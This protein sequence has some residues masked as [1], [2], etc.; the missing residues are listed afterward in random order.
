MAL[1]KLPYRTLV[2]LVRH[3]LSTDDDDTVDLI[4]GLRPARARGYLSPSDLEKV[5]CWKSP[6]AL[7]YIRSNS[8]AHVR[9]AT[10]RAL[11]TRSERR[12]LDAL[13]ELRGVSVPMASAILMLVDPKRYGVIDIRVWQVLHAVG[14]VTKKPSGIG[15][16]FANWYQFLMI[17]RYF[18]KILGVSARDVE[19]ALFVA[20]KDHQKGRL[21]R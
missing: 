20:H 1:Q 19:R 4:R 11:A 12:R 17:L 8:A 7:H 18:S 5:C 6:R 3:Y 16:N 15:F 9:D 14:T 13:L 2:P 10:K 21:Y